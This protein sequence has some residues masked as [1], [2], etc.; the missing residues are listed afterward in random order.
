MGIMW[1]KG[2]IRN[3]YMGQG[4]TRYVWQNSD[5]GRQNSLTQVDLKKVIL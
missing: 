5:T 1:L 2:R 4:D 3:E